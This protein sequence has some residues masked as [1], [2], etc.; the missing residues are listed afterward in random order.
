M[1][2]EITPHLEP[3]LLPDLLALCYRYANPLSLYS[4]SNVVRCA[5]ALVITSLV[6]ATTGRNNHHEFFFPSKYDARN[7]TVRSAV[8]GARVE[9]VVGS[10]MSMVSVALPTANEWATVGA[11]TGCNVLF[12]SAAPFHSFAL[13]ATHPLEVAYERVDALYDS[14][15]HCHALDQYANPLYQEIADHIWIYRDGL[16]GRLTE[17]EQAL[18]SSEQ[19]VYPRESPCSKQFYRTVFDKTQAVYVIGTRD[20]TATLEPIAAALETAGICCSPGLM[21]G[22]LPALRCGPVPQARAAE[23]LTLARAANSGALL[24]IETLV[25]QQEVYDAELERQERDWCARRNAFLA[26]LPKLLETNRCREPPCFRSWQDYGATFASVEEFPARCDRYQE[27]LRWEGARRENVPFQK[28]TI[29]RGR[30]NN[31]E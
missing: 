31:V 10:G 17:E 7:I 19:R 13:E 30:Q 2:D 1:W 5:M 27:L 15:T 11:F 25:A 29:H 20:G 4:V 12:V 28:V 23:V 6:S 24:E 18:I 14:D 8:A 9:L 16:C 3:F 21:Y 26:N 22:A